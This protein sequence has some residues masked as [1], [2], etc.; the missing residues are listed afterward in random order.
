MCKDKI[1]FFFNCS[2]FPD[3]FQCHKSYV[4][5]GFDATVVGNGEKV[6]GDYSFVK[7]LIC[8]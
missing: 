8:E 2:E 4:I 6:S 7:L 1:A 5:Y 3:R